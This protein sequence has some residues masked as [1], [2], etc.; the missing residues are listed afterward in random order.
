M[1]GVDATSAR[2]RLA[3]AVPAAGADVPGRRPSES[4]TSSRDDGHPS[5]HVLLTLRPPFLPDGGLHPDLTPAIA[6]GRWSEEA[7]ASSPAPSGERTPVG[8]WDGMFHVGPG[9]EPRE[10][11]AL[12]VAGDLA[13]GCVGALVLAMVAIAWMA[14]VGA[15]S[16][17]VMT[18]NG[19]R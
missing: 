8:I 3:P 10:N 15:A 14:F 19:G 9:S 6:L 16:V 7:E 18:S 2:L 5:T 1:T 12:A 4:H 17:V 11:L 13:I